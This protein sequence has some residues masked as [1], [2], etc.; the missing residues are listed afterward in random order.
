MIP[1]WGVPLYVRWYTQSSRYPASKNRQTKLR[2]FSSAIRRF[3]ASMS[4][5]CGMLSKHPLMSPSTVHDVREYAVAT[6]SQGGVSA[7][8][9][10]E[11]MRAPEKI[12][13]EDRL[14]D[15][16]QGLLDDPILDGRDAP[17]ALPP[18][19]NRPRDSS[20]LSIRII[21]SADNA[22][23]S[24]ASAGELIPISSSGSLT[25]D[26]PPLH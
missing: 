12:R 11:P 16:S 19:P 22:S 21:P 26:M 9:P 17:S 20:P 2:T 3:T 25:G 8:A 18:H 4:G 5:P 13:L 6:L 1:P 23:S 14:Q 24:Y 7:P 10:P 15:H